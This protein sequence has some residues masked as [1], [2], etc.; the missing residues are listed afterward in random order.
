M[1]ILEGMQMLIQCTKKLLDELGIDPTAV[2]DKDPTF[3]WHANLVTLNRRKTLI[4]IHDRNR[5]V[6]VMYGLRKKD[7]QKLD[8]LIIDTI[9]EA[10]QAECINEEIIHTFLDQAGEAVFARSSDR[11]SLTRLVQAAEFAG[12]WTDMIVEDRVFQAPLSRELSRIPVSAGKGIRGYVWPYEEL[13]RDLEELT[14]KPALECR[15]AVLKVTLELEGFD[16]WR[17][18]L[19]PL[20]TSFTT[21]HKA[22]QIAFGWKDC[23]LHEFFLYGEQGP[24][25]EDDVNHSAFHSEGY[26]PVLHVVSFGD[27]DAPAHPWDIPIRMEEGAKLSDHEFQHAR[28]VYDF[29]DFWRHDIDVEEIIEDHNGNHPIFIDGNGDAPPEDVGGEPG[30][31]HFTRVMADKDDPEHGDWRQWAQGQGYRKSDRLSSVN[32]AKASDQFQSHV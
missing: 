30:F 5:Y 6:I 16:V 20:N 10:L 24:V 25:D 3:S 15:A 13:Y 2:V 27:G 21:L 19:V 28:Y 7:F 22:L 17:R 11:S 29:G 31:G 8:S 12:A 18:I 32:S 23:H 9:R 26:K 4:L 14:G 1:M